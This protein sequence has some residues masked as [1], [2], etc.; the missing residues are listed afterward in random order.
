MEINKISIIYN[1]NH[2]KIINIFGHSFVENNKKNC[3]I[4]YNNKEYNLAS[5]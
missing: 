5:T 4:I 1:I 2:N 3:K